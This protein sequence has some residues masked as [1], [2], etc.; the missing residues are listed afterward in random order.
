[1]GR[2]A[3]WV[4]LA[5][6]T[7]SLASACTMAS[8]AHTTTAHPPGGG[9]PVR[10]CGQSVG[11]TLPAGWRRSTIVLPS[12]ALFT[13][14]AM[15]DDGHRAAPGSRPT[16]FVKILALVRPGVTV[17]LT[18]P[19]AERRFLSLAWSPSHR[20]GLPRLALRACQHPT[21]PGVAGWTQFNGGVNV[22][23]RRCATLEAATGTGT[24]TISLA[25][26]VHRCPG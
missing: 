4:A 11:G 14:G 20:S 5:A 19:A 15:L 16:H 25:I 18:V 7:L 1:M 2:R 24:R 6:A 3:R 23:G 26:G 9:P 22:V 10:G 21:G 13:F 17:T 12:L 8:Q